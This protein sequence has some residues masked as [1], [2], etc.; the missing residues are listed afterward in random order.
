MWACGT[1]A[2]SPPSFI[3]DGGEGRGEGM[4]LARNFIKATAASALKS[5]STPGS[6]HHSPQAFAPHP[7]PLPLHLSK[8]GERASY[9]QG[10]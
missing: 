3:K 6:A 9:R 4:G 5:T 2:P 8:M 7:S 1:S 10:F